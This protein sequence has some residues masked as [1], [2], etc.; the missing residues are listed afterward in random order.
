MFDYLKTLYRSMQL[1]T[2]Y[3]QVAMGT[4]RHQVRDELAALVAMKF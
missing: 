2:Y 1:G 3:N 4:P